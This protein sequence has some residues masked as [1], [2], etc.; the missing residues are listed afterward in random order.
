MF[1]QKELWYINTNPS[2]LLKVFSGVA[3]KI[4]HYIYWH[5][6]NMREEIKDGYQGQPLRSN[7]NVRDSHLDH[8]SMSEAAIE[9]TD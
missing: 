8:R 6:A 9:T 5:L 1:V 7:I 2:S 3:C 4:G